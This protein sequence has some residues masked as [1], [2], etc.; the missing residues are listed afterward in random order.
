MTATLVLPDRTRCSSLPISSSS[1]QSIIIHKCCHVSARV[2]HMQDL[3]MFAATQAL[4]KVISTWTKQ[5]NKAEGHKVSDPMQR[6]VL[7]ALGC[8]QWCWRLS[9]ILPA[10]L[11]NFTM[12]H[13]PYEQSQLLRCL[14]LN[15][16]CLSN[17]ATMLWPTFWPIHK[18][19]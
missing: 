1:V 17:K 12:R 19:A 10:S 11:Y 2:A 6:N 7:E 8:M 14:S 5:K 13:S 4:S 15:L 3:N 16:R 9:A 18:R